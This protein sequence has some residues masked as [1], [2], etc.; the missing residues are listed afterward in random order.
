MQKKIEHWDGLNKRRTRQFKLS[1]VR[2]AVR[3]KFIF[4]DVKALTLAGAQAHFERGL[5]RQ[6]TAK[7]SNI[8]TVQTCRRHGSTDGLTILR[9]LIAHR[10]QYLKGMYIWPDTLERFVTGYDRV[11]KKI[12]IGGHQLRWQR[13]STLRREMKRFNSLKAPAFN[14]LD[15]DFCGI[16]NR[17]NAGTVSRLIQKTV[18]GRGLLFVNHQKGRDGR[19]G[20]LF[21]FIRD[22]FCDAPFDL[23]GIV[24]KY[25]ER[26]DLQYN[27]SLTYD[28]IR[29]IAVPAY[30]VCEAYKHGYT[31]SVDRFIE[32]RD[33]NATSGAGVKMFQWCFRF[34]R[35]ISPK[36]KQ[37]ARKYTQLVTNERAA[38]EYNLNS[39]ARET[40]PFAY[41]VD[42]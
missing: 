38:L 34:V 41:L 16:F 37:Y 35:H 32:Y 13:S 27:D 11:R 24:D 25:G 4:G 39:I 21:D 10:N 28:F 5:V 2:H 12:Y 7:P 36:Y 30:Y 9:S 40:Y 6:K 26:L 1:L 18:A 29:R 22:Y 33:R 19:F 23:F 17:K 31:L 14:V 20:T 42:E 8:I 15:I 3:S